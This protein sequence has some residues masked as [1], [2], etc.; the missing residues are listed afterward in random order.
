ME[1][2]LATKRNK[3]L[4]YTMAKMGLLNMILVK[5]ASEERSHYAR[6]HSY[7]LFRV[8]YPPRQ[9]ADWGFLGTGGEGN[10]LASN[11]SDENV[12]EFHSGDGYTAL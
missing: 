3:V 8:K 7:E 1:Y 9:R 2:Y 10:R 4:V 5:E 11:G 6:F 12:L